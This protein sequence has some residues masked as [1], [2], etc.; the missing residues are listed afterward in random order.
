[1]EKKI[2]LEM[3]AIDDIHGVEAGYY[4]SDAI[5][6]ISICKQWLV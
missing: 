1:M 2:I 4:L 3:E 5:E 6:G